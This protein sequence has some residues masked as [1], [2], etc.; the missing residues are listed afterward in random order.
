[1]NER[2]GPKVHLAFIMLFSLIVAFWQADA[3]FAA[4][5]FRL[6]VDPPQAQY[7]IEVSLDLANKIM[8][9]AETITFRNEMSRPLEVLALDW[10]PQ[11]GSKT[12]EVTEAGRPLRCLN[13]E[14]GSGG[15]LFYALAKPLKK[16]AKIELH[17]KFTRK[18]QDRTSVIAFVGNWHPRLWWEGLPVCDAYKVKLATPPGYVLAISGRLNPASGYYE[19]DNVTTSFG[20]YLADNLKTAEKMSGDVLITALFNKEGEECAR[21]CLDKAAGIIDYYRTLFG[22]F[23]RRSLYIL[24]GSSRPMGGYPMASGIVVIHGEEVFKTMPPLHWEWITSH[25]VGHQYWGEYVMSGDFPYGYTESWLMI[26]L[27]ICTDHE[28]VRYKKLGE[29]MHQ[30]F[31]NR[32][33]DGVQKRVDTTEDA[34]PSLRKLQDYDRNNVL[35]HGKGFSILSALESVVGSETF[36]RILREAL[37]GYGGKRLGYRQFWRL[38]EEVS[39]ENLDWFFE[40]WVRSSKSLCYQVA[41]RNSENTGTLFVSKIVVDAAMDS[42]QMPVPVKAA[43]EDGTSQE[44]TTDRFFGT[45]TLV[46]ESRSMLK[47]VILDPEG[48]LAMLKS[49]LPIVREDLPGLI[50]RLPWEDAGKPALTVFEAARSSGLKDANLW[51]TLGI[52]LIAGGYYAE[53]F[54]AMNAIRESGPPKEMNFL[55]LTWM[56]HLQDLMGERQR[57][58]GYYQEALN[59]DPGGPGMRHDQWGITI[60][61]QWVEERLKTPFK[62]PKK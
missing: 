21:F 62:F 50:N 48:R 43:F 20:I 42:I 45:N 19:N 61:R 53:A 3:V 47:D 56:G 35:I 36:G 28:Y 1:M 51:F 32:Y 16:D 26:G 58:I 57:A 34:P 37:K 41:S 14:R 54:A 30:A 17:M 15:P 24:P 25:E 38:C 31:L 12:L 11:V 22:F 27:G 60:N 59:L 10:V 9:G 13:E 55:A 23:P 8:N 39:G 4:Q 46:F 49:P 7:Q 18:L 40:S 6:P 52:K 2:P 44:K 5:E 29:E 33:L